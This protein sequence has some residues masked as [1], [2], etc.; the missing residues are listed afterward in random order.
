M[1]DTERT[2]PVPLP[3]GAGRIDPFAAVEVRHD[4]AVRS[5][6]VLISGPHHAVRVRTRPGLARSG[7]VLDGQT[8]A[9]ARRVPAVTIPAVT[10]EGRKPL[11][12]R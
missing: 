3:R 8:A 2:L 9:W 1:L 5:W 6:S 10:G 11:M 4:D 7:R 12:I